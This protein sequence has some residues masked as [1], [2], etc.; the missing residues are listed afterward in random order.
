MISEELEDQFIAKEIDIVAAQKRRDFHAVEAV[1]ADGF[2]EIGSSG[3][4]FSKPE[5]LDAIQEI[6]IIDYSFE[7][8]KLLAIDNGYVIVTYI[9][10]V[11]RSYKGQEHW[12]RAYRS[13]IWMER[14]GSW[15]VIFHQATPLPPPQ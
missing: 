8:F 14:E 6:Q 3:R 7:Q 9:A 4:L 10:T 11:K 13:S 12:N 15:R 1:L 5:I 2:H